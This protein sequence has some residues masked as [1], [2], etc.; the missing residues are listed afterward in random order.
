[1]IDW[2]SIGIDVIGICKNGIEAYNMIL[3]E[4][5]DIVMTD[6]RMP[7]LSGLELIKRLADTDH[8]IE[9]IIL[10]GYGEFDYAKE[11]MKCGVKHYLLKPCNEEQIFEVMKSASEDCFKKLAYQNLKKEQQLLTNNLRKHIIRN[12]IVEGLSPDSDFQLLIQ[13]YGKYFDF[14]HTSYEL[15][16]LFFLEEGNLDNCLTQ[17]YDYNL[18]H[19]PSIPLH[20]IYVKNTLLIFFQSYAMDY[21]DF[22]Y[23]INHLEF[24]SPSVN[25]QI[26]HAS[27]SNLKLLLDQMIKKLER[28]E[29]INIMNGLQRIPTCN[30][31]VLFQNVESLSYQ[32]VHSTPEEQP[33]YIS[34]MKD[35]FRTVEDADFLKSLVTNLVLK[36]PNKG[37]YALSPIETTE[38]FLTIGELQDPSAIRNRLFNKIDEFYQNQA[39]NTNKYKDFI[40]SVINY[41]DENLSNPNLSLKWIVENVLFMNV[42]YVSKQFVKQTGNK[43]STYLTNARITKAKELLMIRG[44]DK[45]YTIAEEVGCGNNP[46][47]FSQ[48]F[49]KITGLTPTEYLKKTNGDTDNE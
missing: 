45:I 7:G 28:Y 17:L 33:H 11:A 31:N 44:S 29:M 21:E 5:P 22:D 41:V 14:H 39:N 18:K 3:D 6:I 26:E 32:L 46:Q 25:L 23:F 48:I 13:Q 2:H 16:R 47:Y 35:L 12:I 4:Y 40:D 30:Y 38:L 24:D 9:F 27:Y 10:S 43:F 36:L 34:Q 19:S 15:Y 20:A 1:M 8:T 37:T 49:K 42:D